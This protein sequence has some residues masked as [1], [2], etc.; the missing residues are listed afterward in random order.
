[1]PTISHRDREA[2]SLARRY[3]L[4]VPALLR[5]LLDF[6]LDE[7]CPPLDVFLAER[8]AADKRARTITAVAEA[9]AR[10]NHKTHGRETGTKPGTED[11][12]ILLDKIG[13]ALLETD[14]QDKFC[15]AYEYCIHALNR[16]VPR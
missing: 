14:E 1:M 7:E 13:D 9:C 6:A 16:L 3:D 11:Y 4:S 15:R 8:S 12:Q 2:E 5:I 10:R